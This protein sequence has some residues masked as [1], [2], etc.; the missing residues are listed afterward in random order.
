M[1]RKF[2]LVLIMI[3]V[4]LSACAPAA[5][6]T[7]LPKVIPPTVLPA[8]TTA[9]V[10]VA[11]KLVDGLKREVT[12]DKPAQ[13]IIS[14]APSNTELLFAVG[15]GAQV[16]G[17][18]ELSDYPQA[19]QKVE[20]VGS[21]FGKINAEAIVAL[22]PDLVLAAE[23]NAPE[24]VKSLEDLGL[25]VYYLSNPTDFDGLY[26][27]L[28]IVGA[29]TG[30][31]AEADQLSQSI[32]ARYKAVIEKVAASSSKPKVFYEIDATDPTK[33][34]TAGAGTFIDR[35]IDLAG[36]SNIGQALKDQFAA[37]SSEELIKQDP[38]L[39]ILG[40][41]A[42]GVTSESVGQRAGWDKIAA[43]KNKA[44]FGFDDNLASR[45]GPR[46]IDGL[47]QLAK[48]IH[49]ELFK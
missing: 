2:S 22:K 34:F 47:E 31:A 29:L 40:D 26:E 41:S 1:F 19:A 43:V 14:I 45:P 44:I 20:S 8:A 3:T 17:R 46:L 7:A 39:I 21:A 13:R 33:P 30:H 24:Q 15:A 37:I 35:L 9:P 16:V 12:L 5:T 32:A 10:P 25:T 11:I 4:L 23:I 48:L 36:G 38:D 18:E 6:P 42:Y 28:K 49:P 27:N